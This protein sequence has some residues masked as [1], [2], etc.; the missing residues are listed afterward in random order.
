MININ[1]LKYLVQE[2]KIF[3]HR[4]LN[5]MKNLNKNIKLIN[6]QTRYLDL[7]FDYIFRYKTIIIKS[8]TGTAKS[9][10]LPRI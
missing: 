8:D 7:N 6:L 4:N 10:L 2:K 3:S 5:S 1:Y 9:Q